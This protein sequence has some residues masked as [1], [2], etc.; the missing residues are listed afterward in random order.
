[1]KFDIK[2]FDEYRVD[3]YRLRVRNLTYEGNDHLEALRAARNAMMTT[4]GH[5][6]I[7]FAA[8]GRDGKTHQWKYV[9]HGDG[10][11]VVKAAVNL[12]AE[13]DAD[14]PGRRYALAITIARAMLPD[15]ASAEKWNMDSDKN[16][17][18]TVVR[19]SGFS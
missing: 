5:A 11:L 17:I 4:K 18:F 10:L 8:P 9:L 2:L 6:E 13:I 15:L 1:M 14:D 12:P 3:E 19:F 16:G 7:E